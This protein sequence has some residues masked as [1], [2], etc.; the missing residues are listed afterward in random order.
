[1]VIQ[2]EQQKSQQAEPAAA[3]AGPNGELKFQA[4]VPE[5]AAEHVK[6]EEAHQRSDVQPGEGPPGEPGQQ[7]KKDS[8]PSQEHPVQQVHP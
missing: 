3:A 1:A 4:Q 8:V 6:Q 5:G 7:D 2:M